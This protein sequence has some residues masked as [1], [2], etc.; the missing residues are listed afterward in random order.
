MVRVTWLHYYVR[1]AG[2]TL[3]QER[4]GAAMTGLHLQRARE[5]D[6]DRTD[7][8][9]SKPEYEARPDEPQGS[10][11]GTACQHSLQQCQQLLTLLSPQDYACG[12]D[13][14]ASIGAHVRHILER[15]QC[16]LAGLPEGCVDYDDRSR[17]RTLEKNPQAAAFALATIL[18]RMGDLSVDSRP[19]QIRESVSSEAPAG[20]ADSTVKRELLSLISHTTHHLAMI[21][22]VARSLG[23]ELDDDFGKAASTIIFEQQSNPG[24]N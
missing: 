18:R 13:D 23:Y 24:A 14:T 12:S 8:T 15:F 17:D 1:V 22:M 4:R 19:L 5:N 7:M 10:N 21:A 6:E 11:F 2:Q 16:F 9:T 20:E 3:G